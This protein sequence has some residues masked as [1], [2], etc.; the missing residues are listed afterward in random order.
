MPNGNIERR[1]EKRTEERFQ[2]IMTK[3]FPK[4]MLD[5]KTQIQQAQRTPSRIIAGKTTTVHIIF[6]LQENKDK[7]KILREDRGEK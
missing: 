6:K 4:S 5:T 2:N 7:E 3:N 1:T